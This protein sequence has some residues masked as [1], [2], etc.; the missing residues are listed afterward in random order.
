VETVQTDSEGKYIFEHLEPGSYAVGI[1]T[2]IKG[3]TEYLLPVAGI[4]EDNQFADFNEDYTTVYSEEIPMEED[5]V[6]VDINAGLHTPPGI[7]AASVGIQP[8]KDS[9]RSNLIEIMKKGDR[10]PNKMIGTY[11]SFTSWSSFIFIMNCSAAFEKT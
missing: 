10:M 4:T 6:V 8:S 11:L 2:C 3:D 9:G 5:T 1:S 7:V